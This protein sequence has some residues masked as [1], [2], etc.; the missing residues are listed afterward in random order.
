MGAARPA[1]RPGDPKPP[2]RPGAPG[3]K[4]PEPTPPPKWRE[5]LNNPA[6]VASIFAIA[7]LAFVT[8]VPGMFR[9]K[10]PYETHPCCGMKFYDC[11]CGCQA[12]PS[13]CTCPGHK[14]LNI[15]LPPGS[16]VPASAKPASGNPGP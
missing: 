14:T 5:Y 9:T 13:A 2:A 10:P 12:T 1:A 8:Q 6:V 16:A 15:A 3:K 11:K 7:V 4:P